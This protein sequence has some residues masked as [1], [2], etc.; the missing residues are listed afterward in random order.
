MPTCD[1]K[2]VALLCDF[3]EIT[4]PHGCSSVNLLH[5]FRTPFL[6]NTSR[7]LLPDLLVVNLVV[8]FILI[9]RFTT[10]FG[11][12]DGAASALS[13]YFKLR[14]SRRV[15]VLGFHY[16]NLRQSDQNEP[17]QVKL[18]WLLPLSKHPLLSLRP[19]RE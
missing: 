14:L 19:L 5:I 2:K 4:L 16:L 6:S 9:Y 7:W 17:V 3:I 12:K 8:I 13:I 15:L 1:F 18:V 10:P 11:S